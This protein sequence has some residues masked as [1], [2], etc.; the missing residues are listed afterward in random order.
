MFSSIAYAG[1]LSCSVTTAAGC[2]DTVIYRMS[3]AAN[4]QAELPS[5]TT[6]AYDNNVVCCTGI[7]G[8]SNAC[9]GTYAT[10]LKLSSTTNAHAEQNDQTNYAN[11]VCLSVPSGGSVSVGY[12][13]SSCTGFDATLGSMSGVTNAHVGDNDAYTTK[14]CATAIGAAPTVG[15][16]SLNG[17]S[18]ISLL[19]NTT[20]AVNVTAT[21]TDTQG[22]S[23]I[24][25]VTAKTYRSGVTP[26]CTADDNNCYSVS[27]SQDGGSC[28][29]AGDND[30]T[31]TCA[32]NIYYFA[33]PT[34]SGS[35]WSDNIWQAGVQATDSES[36][37]GNGTNSSQN[38]EMNTLRAL[39]A[40]SSISYG[41]LAPNNST[42]TLN[43]EV[44]V[45]NTGNAGIDIELSGENMTRTGGG[46]IDVGQQEYTILSGTNYGAGQDLSGTAA[47]LEVDLSKPTSQT[48]VTDII[49]WGILIPL[50]ALAGDYNGTNTIGAVAD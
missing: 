50:N 6:S 36:L 42:G 43:K 41:N 45:T 47:H 35:P 49:Y 24:S 16:V 7:V 38:V 3:D 31:Y 33:Q 48:A 25:T 34:D 18:N 1:T 19:E 11:S 15:D 23:T 44:T 20:K 4:A 37:S 5:Q 2:S 30:A 13:S 39:D 9:A 10:A 22:C 32:I 12:Q 8:L 21:V 28:T 46:S 17:N 40:T 29:G 27:C 26:A 14:I